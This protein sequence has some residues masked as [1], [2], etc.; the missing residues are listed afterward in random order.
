MDI[1][2]LNKHGG[3]N[4]DADFWRWLDRYLFTF[5]NEEIEPWGMKQWAPGWDGSRT[6][7]SLLLGYELSSTVLSG[8]VAIT[9]RHIPAGDSALV[10]Y[11]DLGTHR[12][13]F[14]SLP[15]GPC[16]PRLSWLQLMAATSSFQGLK[17]SSGEFW[18][19]AAPWLPSLGATVITMVPSFCTRPKSLH[20]ASKYIIL[21]DSFNHSVRW[22]NSFYR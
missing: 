10:I 13:T 2:A 8:V 22:A 18:K 14:Q 9:R 11:G 19:T 6:Q 7:V 15:Q 4:T 21:F 16:R 12:S 17:L 1:W 5:L 20:N 3:L